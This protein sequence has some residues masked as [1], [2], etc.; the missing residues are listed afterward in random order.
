MSNN[1][2]GRDQGAEPNT[3]DAPLMP[4]AEETEVEV[5]GAV[6]KKGE[7][8]WSAL[9]MGAGGDHPEELFWDDRNRIVAEC[10]DALTEEGKKVTIPTVTD[11]LRNTGNEEAFTRSEER[12]VGKRV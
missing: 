3:S 9:K 8:W 12:R 2:R 11:R 10:I 4:S 7:T 1:E 5:L 6:L